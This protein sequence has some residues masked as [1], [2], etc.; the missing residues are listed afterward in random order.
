MIR[1]RKRSHRVPVL[2]QLSMVECGAACLAMILSYHGRPTRVAECRERC[3][4]GRD[5]V[6]ALALAQAARGFGLRVRAFTVE[7]AAFQ[8]IPLPAI[9]HWGF[10]HFVVV[11]HWSPTRVTV[12]D[13]AKGR[14]RLTAEEFDAGFTGVVLACEPGARFASQSA[15]RHRSWRSLDYARRFVTQAPG[16]LMQVLAASLLLQVLGLALPVATQVLVDRV[17]PLRAAGVL[18][19]LG[20]GLAVVVLAQV[21][22]SLLRSVLL[23]ALQ[24]RVDSRLMLGFFEHLLTLPFRF[25]EQRTTGDLMMRLGSNAIV[26]E[27]LTSQT[28]SLALDGSLVIGYLAFLLARDPVFGGIVL[29]IALIQAGLLIATRGRMHD[30]TQRDLAA[31]GASQGYLVEA[32]A[33]I[34]TLK[35]SGA[36]QTTLGRW[37]DLFTE[38]LNVSLR[39]G[40]FS[41]VLD[42]LT[43]GFR[44]LAPLALLLVGADRVLDNS[45]SLGTMLALQALAT[46]VLSPLGA[47]I[48][49]G[50]RL[51]MVGAHIDRLSDVLEAAPEQDSKTV[52]PAPVL[53]GELTLDGVGFHY[54][55]HAPWVLRNVSLS[56]E[57]GQ[58]IALVGPS[59]SGKSTLAKLLLGLYVPSEGALQFD[60]LTLHDLDLQTV[61]RQFG[62]VLQEPVLFSGSIRQNIAFNDPTLPLERIRDAARLAAIDDDIMRLPMGYETWLSEGGGGLSGGQRQ[63]LALARALA[64][65]PAILLL[66]EAT[67]HLDVATEALVERNLVGLACTRIVIAHRL[68]T[69][70]DADLILVLD[71]GTI[72]ERGRHEELMRQGGHYAALV[73]S[74]VGRESSEV[75][76]CVA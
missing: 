76:E 55:A 44:T 28:L 36:E 47:L 75:T 52:R 50:Q 16:V 10:E 53:S 45:M 68:S 14:Q 27:T 58:K 26:R 38:Q 30:L 23:L 48:S 60:G 24:A 20:L 61:R 74:Q 54:D 72:V 33:G 22:T 67:S 35:A 32:L 7:P 6:T 4:V 70:R 66:D 21:V 25:F 69:V 73:G 8:Q 34:A 3:G 59:G 51:Q 43:T 5:G 65:N 57:P 49:N 62:V 56:I 18:P 15:A 39:R 9:A 11:E 71:G 31:Q 37:S 46:G 41:A 12:V 13:P 17:L 40:Q 64:G 1:S 2:L 42:N 19:V 63:R 29:A